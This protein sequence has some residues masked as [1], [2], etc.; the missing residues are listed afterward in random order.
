[1]K[2]IT[3]SDNKVLRSTAE[4]V[5]IFDE[6]LKNLVLK[7]MAK[8]KNPEVEDLEGV[9]L[10]ANQVGILKRI[11]VMQFNVNTKKDNKVVAMINPEIK[12]LSD[13]KCWMEEG[14]LSVP[15]LYEKVLRPSIVHAEWQDVKGKKYFKKLKNW[16]ARIFLHEHDHLDGKLFIDYEN[17]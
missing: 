10:A 5:E 2:I 12:K 8:M 17:R 15:G 9:G 16:D 14:C 11:L 4:K 1:M 7:M 6:K 3:D 13:E